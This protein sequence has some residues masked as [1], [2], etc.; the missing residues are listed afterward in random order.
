LL[1]VDVSEWIA[2]SN[3]AALFAKES[4]TV[5]KWLSDTDDPRDA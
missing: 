3:R 1:V 4:V 5:N 2:A